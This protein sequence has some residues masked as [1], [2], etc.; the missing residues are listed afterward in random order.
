MG[1]DKNVDVKKSCDKPCIR[2]NDLGMNETIEKSEQAMP[3]TKGN[4]KCQSKPV[5]F[6]DMD[7]ILTI[8]E[9]ISKLKEEIIEIIEETGEVS[10]PAAS[11]I[12]TKNKKGNITDLPTDNNNSNDIVSSEKF[13][14]ETKQSLI[15]K[16]EEHKSV[17]QDSPEPKEQ[18]GDWKTEEICKSLSEY[19]LI[20]PLNKTVKDVKSK[21]AIVDDMHV[22]KDPEETNQIQ[23]N[24]A[25]SSKLDQLCQKINSERNAG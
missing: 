14:K 23:H 21:Y 8:D 24:E 9:H 15:E 5:L 10:N 4:V 20:N 19:E 12:Q 13:T 2:E 6:S 17:I 25:A 11:I 18:G 16:F 7:E 1:S 3:A 22:E